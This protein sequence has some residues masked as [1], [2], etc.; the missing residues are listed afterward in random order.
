MPIL[1]TDPLPD[2]IKRIVIEVQILWTHSVVNYNNC[3]AEK[4][5]GMHQLLAR[6]AKECPQHGR[7]PDLLYYA[8]NLCEHKGDKV[9]ANKFYRAAAEEKPNDTIILSNLYHTE[10]TDPHIVAAKQ[11]LSKYMDPAFI[12]AEY[13]TGE[14]CLR[15]KDPEL[16]DKLVKILEPAGLPEAK[17]LPKPIAPPPKPFVRRYQNPVSRPTKNRPLDQP[18]QARPRP[19]GRVSRGLDVME[20]YDSLPQSDKRRGWRIVKEPGPQLRP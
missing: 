17:P 15:N 10:E 1:P 7:N 3:R 9:Q 5:E 18:P 6:V 4:I 8:G 14:R 20:S 11:L 19:K 16:S 2:D 13:M 12:I